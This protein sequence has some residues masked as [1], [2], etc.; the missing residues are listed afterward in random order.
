MYVCICNSVTDSDIREAVN[1]GATK[2][3]HLA[4]DLKVG[5]CC[6]KCTSCAKRVLLEAKAERVYV[7]FTES[8]RG[9][10]NELSSA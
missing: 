1:Q 9:G 3:G 10:T 2:F 4:R 6:G 8:L 7:N 5:T